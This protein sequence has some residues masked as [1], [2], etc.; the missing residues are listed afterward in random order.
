MF[1]KY[2][3][4]ILEN[5]R[6]AA[7]PTVT[8]CLSY[9]HYPNQS[10]RKTSQPNQSSELIK[11]SSLA[12]AIGA[13]TKLASFLA[14]FQTGAERDDC[15]YCFVLFLWMDQKKNPCHQKEKV[16]VFLCSSGGTNEVDKGGSREEKQS[17][18]CAR[19]FKT[20][21]SISELLRTT[22]VLVAIPLL[23]TQCLS[24]FTGVSWVSATCMQNNSW[25]KY[26]L[27]YFHL[28][29]K[30]KFTDSI[31]NFKNVCC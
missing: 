17:G 18:K 31:S 13:R 19:L 12:V 6:M 21:V 5:K 25:L 24:K 27:R 11:P 14:F 16:H 8:L 30:K 4:F 20:L 26:Q 23:H 3:I 10:S 1:H 28:Q 7:F 15:F 29:V 2:E 22:M 9:V